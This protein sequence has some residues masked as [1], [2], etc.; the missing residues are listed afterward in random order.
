MCADLRHRPCDHGV[1]GVNERD[2]VILVHGEMR[3]EQDVARANQCPCTLVFGLAVPRAHAGEVNVRRPAVRVTDEDAGIAVGDIVL[4]EG[5]GDG[6]GF[7]G[8]ARVNRVGGVGEGIA[9][10]VSVRDIGVCGTPILV[11]TNQEIAVGV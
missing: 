8:D 4:E 11:A 9:R 2:G 7:P 10:D 1:V 5:E 6:G 3:G